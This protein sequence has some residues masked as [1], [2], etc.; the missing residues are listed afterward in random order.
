MTLK[1]NMLEF[2]LDIGNCPWRGV[3]LKEVFK[4]E[5]VSARQFG[6]QRGVFVT[7]VGLLESLVY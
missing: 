4:L 7:G 5:D 2:Y 3:H 6:H 1:D